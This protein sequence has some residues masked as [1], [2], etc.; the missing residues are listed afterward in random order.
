MNFLRGYEGF[1]NF[2]C[3]T[4]PHFNY[5]MLINQTERGKINLRKNCF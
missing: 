3:R 4:S 2:G 5:G 1:F